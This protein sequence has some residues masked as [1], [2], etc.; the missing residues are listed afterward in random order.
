M[1]KALI[2]LGVAMALLSCEAKKSWEVTTKITEG[3]Y[4]TVTGTFIDSRVLSEYKEIVVDMSDSEIYSYCTGGM[5]IE[6][7]NGIMYKTVTSK[8][9]K[10]VK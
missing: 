5:T 7:F 6:T 2:I 10:E 8:T 1:R 3:R 9:Y 4:K